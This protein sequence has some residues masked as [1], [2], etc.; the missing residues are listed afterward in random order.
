MHNLKSTLH[1][2]W[3]VFALFYKGLS[4]KFGEKSFNTAK[5]L[6]VKVMQKYAKFN[7]KNL[8]N[9]FLHD[10]NLLFYKFLNYS[11]SK[12]TLALFCS[13]L[14][15]K[16]MRKISKSCQTIPLLKTWFLVFLKT[17]T[18]KEQKKSEKIIFLTLFY[19]K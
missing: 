5:R 12:I 3:I 19:Y 18:N 13:R 9:G 11:L 1:K 14:F 16:I 7:E 17:F 4:R 2:N 15:Y 6:Y 8:S 10:L